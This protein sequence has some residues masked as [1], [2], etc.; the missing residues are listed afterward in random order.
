MKAVLTA[1]TFTIA[2]FTSLASDVA[3]VISPHYTAQNSDTV[4]KTA[5][6]I[7]K[8]LPIDSSLTVVSGI[9]GA[10]VAR[11]DIPDKQAFAYEQ[12]RLKQ[13]ASHLRTLQHFTDNVT[14]GERTYGALNTPAVLRDIARNYPGITDIVLMGSALYDNPEHPALAMTDGAYPSDD[15]ILTPPTTSIFGT[16]GVSLLSA[17]RIHW[18]LSAPFDDVLYGEAVLRFYHLYIHALGGELVSFTANN[19]AV[20][21]QLVNGASALPF[22]YQ[23]DPVGRLQM[24]RLRHAVIENAETTTHV[25][26]DA[27][28]DEAPAV[29]VGIEWQN[30]GEDSNIDLDIYAGVPGQAVLYFGNTLSGVGVHIKDELS[31]DS[32]NTQFYERIEF[33]QGVD[34]DALRIAVNVYDAPARD[35]ALTGILRVRVEGKVYQTPF[36]LD[37]ARGGNKGAD[38]D[39][40][41]NDGIDTA[42]T[43][44]FTVREIMDASANANASV[45]EA[46]R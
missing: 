25:S 16:K 31:G 20:I 9:D 11:F 12:V 39:G 44:F 28:T 7:F 5:Y 42:F 10:L 41:L 14:Q 32:N 45:E 40:V 34:I 4:F 2:S 21:E 13:F 36:S 35:A 29:R 18:A 6:S 23:L 22:I 17:K 43:R 38:V 46:V 27:A 8:D 3:L 19:Q 15:F 37:L 24:Q 33:R 30:I 26:Q 1:L